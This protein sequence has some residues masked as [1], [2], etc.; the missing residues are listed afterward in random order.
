MLL[1]RLGLVSHA[2]QTGKGRA[3]APTVPY[4]EIHVTRARPMRRSAVLD[5]R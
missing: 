3:R 2:W 4:D 5:S 1:E